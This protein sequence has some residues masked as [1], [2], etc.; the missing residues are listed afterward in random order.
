MAAAAAMPA[1]EF[2]T[3]GP[4]GRKVSLVLQKRGKKKPNCGTTT[5]AKREETTQYVLVGILLRSFK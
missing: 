5:A 3:T 1:A 4:R 2:G